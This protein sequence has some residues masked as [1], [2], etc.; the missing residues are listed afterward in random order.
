M[1]SMG[2][3]LAGIVALGLAA[4]CGGQVLSTVGDAGPG[5]EAGAPDSTSSSSSGSSGSSGSSSGSS[6]G[7]SSG[8]SSG[9]IADAGP[10][11]DA[12]CGE[13]GQPCCLTWTC[14]GGTVCQGGIACVA[15]PSGQTGCNGLCYD[16]SNDPNNCGACGVACPEAGV[17]DN[18]SCACV[19][20]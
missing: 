17:C 7:G 3:W 8:S 14:Y 11:E 6:S 15:C 19:T 18:G 2:R 10:G 12:S 1:S 9:G 4:S 20:G 16:Q 13:I 5:T